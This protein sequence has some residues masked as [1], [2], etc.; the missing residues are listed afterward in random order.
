MAQ[1]EWKDKHS[2]T[3]HDG[4]ARLGFLHAGERARDENDRC[5]DD[6]G[7]A[8]GQDRPGI[9]SS[10]RHQLEYGVVCGVLVR[11][12]GPIRTLE[13]FPRYGLRPSRARIDGGGH[14]AQNWVQAA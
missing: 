2:L 3:H 4:Q 11:L 12:A 7:A 1:G 14:A 10:P 13:P 6:N 8:S 5:D 9:A